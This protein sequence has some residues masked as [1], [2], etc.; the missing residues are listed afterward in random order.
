MIT[1]I[2]NTDSVEAASGR[3][4]SLGKEDFLKLLVAQLANQDP[5]NPMD[6]TELTAQ[7]AQFSSL[8][9]LF[10]INSNMKQ[11]QSLQESLNETQTLGYLGREVIAEGDTL[12][13]A[14]GAAEVNYSLMNNSSDVRM[15][16]YNAAGDLVKS[17]SLGALSA[18]DQAYLW[19]GRDMNGIPMPDGL[20]T[21]ELAASGDDGFVEAVGYITGMVDSIRYE[22]GTPLL[23]V[24]G[25]QI[26]IGDIKTIK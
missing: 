1:A 19:D 23:Y 25:V 6:N 18:G 21:F 20:Y 16:I 3:S 17:A 9:Q 26:S 15:G 14:N 13:L 8:E 7:L 10:D 12:S 22:S 5:L 24:N 2:T 11:F 4:V